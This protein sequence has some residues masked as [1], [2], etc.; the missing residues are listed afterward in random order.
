MEDFAKRLIAFREKMELNPS[1]FAKKVGL[2]S[3]N[4]RAYE[5]GIKPSSDVIEK[6]SNAF[7]ELNLTWL[8]T[9]MRNDQSINVESTAKLIHN[10]LRI[11]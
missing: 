7:D 1:E 8:K 10:K 9:Y 4:I 6:I 11:G 3:S 5:K 2:G